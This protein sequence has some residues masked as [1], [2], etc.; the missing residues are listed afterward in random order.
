MVLF[1]FL[2]PV[3]V[4]EAGH[5]LSCLLQKKQLS[6]TLVLPVQKMK[7]DGE[8]PEVGPLKVIKRLTLRIN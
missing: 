2:Q 4:G 5:S 6:Q 3:L 1:F 8:F 7:G